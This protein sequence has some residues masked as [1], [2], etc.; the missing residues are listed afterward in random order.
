MNRP[1]SLAELLSEHGVR[2]VE[3]PSQMPPERQARVLMDILPCVSRRNPFKVGDLLVQTKN[4]RAYQGLENALCIVTEIIHSPPPQHKSGIY[5]RWD[6]IVA[7][8]HQECSTW[9]EAMVE[10]WRFE[11]YDGPVE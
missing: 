3:Q 1:M 10:S 11:R 2:A 8:H 6:I 9:V 4:Y 7:Y 5:N